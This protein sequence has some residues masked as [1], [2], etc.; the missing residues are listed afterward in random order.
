VHHITHTVTAVPAVQR[1]L[2]ELAGGHGPEFDLQEHLPQGKQA[3]RQRQQGGGGSGGGGGG[4]E[5]GAVAAAAEE[6]VPMAE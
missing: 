5:E 6:P 1:E 4:S 2:H 3:Q